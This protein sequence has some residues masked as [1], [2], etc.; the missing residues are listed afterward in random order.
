MMNKGTIK[1]FLRPDW[2]KII[3]TVFLLWLPF[4]EEQIP[5][6]GY[7]TLVWYRIIDRLFGFLA[8]PLCSMFHPTDTYCYL[9]SAG[10][11]QTFHLQIPQY[12]LLLLLTLIVVEIISVYLFTCLIIFIYNKFRSKK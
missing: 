3:L 7:P 4:C 11:I 1:E 5:F 8:K 2:K 9:Y 6:G 12:H 10:P